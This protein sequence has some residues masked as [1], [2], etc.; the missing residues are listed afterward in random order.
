[1]S[2]LLFALNF[3]QILTA[4]GQE[5]LR[6]VYHPLLH[7][8][9]FDS[10]DSGILTLFIHGACS[11]VSAATRTDLALVWWNG[12]CDAI[13]VAP[14]ILICRTLLCSRLLLFLSPT[15]VEA[16]TQSLFFEDFF[17]GEATSL[18]FWNI[19]E[20]LRLRVNATTRALLFNLEQTRFDHIMWSPSTLL[21]LQQ[22]HWVVVSTLEA[23]L[24]HSLAL[25]ISFL[26]IEHNLCL[27]HLTFTFLLLIWIAIFLTQVRLQVT[28]PGRDRADTV[29]LACVS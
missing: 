22:E 8:E 23:L 27:R 3:V 17:E 28:L 9:V 10:H 25:E 26:W 19:A 2:Q 13:G 18:Q 6:I 11:T 4:L 5:R 12:C 7:L 1:M 24:L 16:E 15:P 21:L 29:H 14:R 20:C